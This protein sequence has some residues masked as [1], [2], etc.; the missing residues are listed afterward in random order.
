MSSTVFSG[1]IFIQY[2]C[3][4]HEIPESMRRNYRWELAQSLKA[5]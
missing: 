2:F 5:P 1:H 4:L 3:N